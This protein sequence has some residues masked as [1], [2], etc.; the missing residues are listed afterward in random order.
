[1]GIGARHVGGELDAV[2]AAGAST[3][4]GLTEERRPDPLAA[5]IWVHVH[6]LDL[7]A[8]PAARLE[9]PEHEQLAQADHLTTELGDEHR[10]VSR[11]DLMERAPVRGQ[12]F[13]NLSGRRA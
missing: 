2:A 7:G 12:V 10:P 6:R 1:M 13:R 9:V 5:M 8:E 4:H 11:L 3:R